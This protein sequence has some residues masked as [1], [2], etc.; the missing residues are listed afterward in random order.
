MKNKTHNI[1]VK[2]NGK[3]RMIYCETLSNISQNKTQIY[4]INKLINLMACEICEILFEILKILKILW[5]MWKNSEISCL[6]YH[7]ISPY[8]SCFTI[9][10]C[11]LIVQHQF[12]D[13][14]RPG[15]SAL[16]SLMIMSHH[17]WALACFIISTGMLA[18]VCPWARPATHKLLP[19][20]PKYRWSSLSSFSRKSCSTRRRRRGGRTGSP[21]WPAAAARPARRPRRRPLLAWGLFSVLPG[22]D[23]TDIMPGR[24]GRSEP[25][26]QWAARRSEWGPRQ[27][28][29]VWY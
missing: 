8:F 19:L 3:H 10:Y 21:P 4:C 27:G 28:R 12:A 2:L 25:Q 15:A 17:H 13:G 6:W 16:D 26:P 1:F 11:T 9:Q 29:V 23:T 7:H 20:G 14:R 24:H 18:R 22:A 5:N